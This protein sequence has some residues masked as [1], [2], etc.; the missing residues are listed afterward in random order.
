MICQI[1]PPSYLSLFSKTPVVQRL[2]RG[3]YTANMGVRVSP[4]VP[5]LLSQDRAVVAYKVHALEVGRFDSPSCNQKFWCGS[6][7]VNAIDSYSIDRVFKS[8]PHHQFYWGVFKCCG[9]L[10]N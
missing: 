6:I 4:R 1:V 3:S 10:I 7:V 2:G 5:I 8:H 9:Y